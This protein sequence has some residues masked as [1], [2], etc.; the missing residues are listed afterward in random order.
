[1]SEA[2]T[3]NG[4]KPMLLPP[5]LGCL[6]VAPLVPQAVQRARWRST[7]LDAVDLHRMTAA[8]KA[9]GARC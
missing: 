2:S 4:M 8:A 6:S 1:M 5:Q 9:N 3:G 7:S